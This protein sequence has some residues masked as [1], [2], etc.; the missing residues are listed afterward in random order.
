VR[1]IAF[2]VAADGVCFLTSCPITY[3]GPAE[4]CVRGKR[5][6]YAIGRHFAF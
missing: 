5:S 3:S 2:N 4:V 6:V 1:Q